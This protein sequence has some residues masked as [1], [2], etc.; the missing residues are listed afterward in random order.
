MGD[1]DDAGMTQRLLLEQAVIIDGQ[2]PR[3]TDLTTGQR[4]AGLPRP[5]VAAMIA[6]R[7]GR[8]R[9]AMRGKILGRGAAAVNVIEQATR[10]HVVRWRARGAKCHIKWL[11]GQVMTLV[12]DVQT[13]LDRRMARLEG[14][15]DLDQITLGEQY[16]RRD[17]Q[18]PAVALTL[19]LTR[20]LQVVFK[21]ALQC[22]Q[23]AMYRLHALANALAL[24]G[25]AYR[26][27]GADQQ[28]RS[29]VLLQPPHLLGKMSTR[30]AQRLG[31]PGEAEGF[32][33]LSEQHQ[34]LH[35]LVMPHPACSS[36]QPS[37]I[38]VNETATALYVLA[39]NLFVRMCLSDLQTRPRLKASLD[40]TSPLCDIDASTRERTPP[41]A[42]PRLK[43]ATNA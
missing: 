15:A 18:H 19:R 36:R 35:L 21:L 4:P 39:N 20:L 23:L 10:D 29:D 42:I 12:T 13:Q 32:R 43:I 28:G 5:D 26:P 8:V 31:R 27:C 30:H 37:G 2:S 41:C 38:S 40:V 34:S 17:A 11:A 1:P 24:L 9:R 7:R 22:Q 3:E 25:E 6:K 33:H 16:R 14:I